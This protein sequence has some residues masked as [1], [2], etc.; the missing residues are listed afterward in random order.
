MERV[1]AY[2][3]SAISAWVRSLNL[4]TTRLGMTNT[5]PGTTGFKLTK[6]IESSDWKNTCVALIT[7]CP[8][9]IFSKLPCKMFICKY[10]K[11]I[12]KFIHSIN[13]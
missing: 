2:I 3:K 13:N 5:W 11:I 10:L 7:Y 12:R 9:I 8:G 1:K 6:P 4:G